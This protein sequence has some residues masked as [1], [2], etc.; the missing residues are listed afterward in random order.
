M[1]TDPA[2]CGWTFESPYIFAGNTPI[3]AMD[4]KGEKIYFV[5][6]DGTILDLSV[7][8]NIDKI[9]DPNY[10]ETYKTLIKTEH[11]KMILDYYNSNGSYHDIYMKR[12][13]N[14]AISN[15]NASTR[16]SIDLYE[17]ELIE[18]GKLNTEKYSKMYTNSLYSM[19]T[20]NGVDVSKSKD[21]RIDLIEFNS[22]RFNI[23]YNIAHHVDGNQ[24]PIPNSFYSF[25]MDKYD[26][27]EALYH[28]IVAHIL[29]G[30]INKNAG[31]TLD[32]NKYGSETSKSMKIVLNPANQFEIISNELLFLKLD[33]SFQNFEIIVTPRNNGTMQTNGTS[34]NNNNSSSNNSN[35]SS[36]ADCS[37]EGCTD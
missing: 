8:A 14:Q 26:L 16:H 25:S 34:N 3:V 6:K 1:T 9:D 33:E 21:K 18:S 5:N 19:Q 35:S 24:K 28:E 29:Y 13:Y 22:F 17:P 10:K 15:E 27:A 31:A 23:G 30:D 7:V 2:H 4:K 37:N 12:S 36:E 11:G 20:F 32:H